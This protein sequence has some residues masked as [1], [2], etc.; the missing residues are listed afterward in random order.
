MSD[1]ATTST[2]DLF[3]VAALRVVEARA[4]EAIGDAGTLMQ[5]A[6]LAAWHAVLTHWPQ[7]QRLVVA[8]G[9]GNN[10]GDGYVLAKHARRAGRAVSVVRLHDHSPRG[11]LALRAAGDYADAGGETLV[12][13][14][15]LPSADLIVD[16]L[17]GIGLSRPP[18]NDAVRLIEAINAAGLPVL[19]IDVPSGVDAD[20]GV[21]PGAA[22]S[23]TRTLECIAGHPGLATGD[24]LAL[25][26][27]REIAA[28][29]LEAAL[30]EGLHPAAI[31]VDAAAVARWLAPR[32]RNAHKGDSGRV[33]CIGGDHGKGGA[34]ALCADA[35]LRGGAGLVDVATRAAHVPALLARRPE[36]MVHGVD[37][38]PGDGETSAVPIATL[39]EQAS[40]V[41][42]GTGLGQDAWGRALLEAAMQAC[43]P[44][45]VDADALNL[46]ATEPR[47]LPAGTILTPHPGEAARLLSSTAK[48][49]Q[50]DRF[51]AARTLSDRF[52]CVVVLKGAGT[53]IAAPGAT[54]RVIDAGNPG[55]AVGGMGDL[56][57]GV[58]AA[59]RAQGL[60]ALDAATCGALVH[61]L[62]G[63]R[64]A[65]DGGERGLLPTDL[66]PRLRR[67]VNP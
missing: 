17:F 19:A 29:D 6:G 61:G 43:V 24:G 16:A 48:D 58:I 47:T 65:A 28:L 62:A 36:L 13:D 60:A 41:A 25:A 40:V 14:G 7:A 66:L 56:L 52:G 23:A 50:A 21:M 33:L 9:P 18:E 5:R 3:D 39:I 31:R 46:I 42:I 67:L 57:T 10:G 4:V 32:G 37:L 45:V 51:R 11:V 34:I 55:M 26:G 20:R 15:L 54:T 53:L 30:F 8:C 27:A 64:A 2:H 59:L 44:L 49:I 1:P 63:D 35:A 38:E 12:F 22:V